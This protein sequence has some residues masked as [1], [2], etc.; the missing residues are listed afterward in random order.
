MSSCLFPSAEEPP[1]RAVSLMD[2]EV[3]ELQIHELAEVAYPSNPAS[4]LLAL[5]SS[6]TVTVTHTLSQLFDFFDSFA[7]LTMLLVE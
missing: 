7:N 4:R 1:Q 6:I 5:C 2:M 3:D